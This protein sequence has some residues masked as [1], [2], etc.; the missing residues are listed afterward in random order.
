[1]QQRNLKCF[2]LYCRLHTTVRSQWTTLSLSKGCFTD[3]YNNYDR[4]W[5]PFRNKVQVSI[6][7]TFNCLKF[8]PVL[9]CSDS[10][11]SFNAMLFAFIVLSVSMRSSSRPENWRIISS[12]LSTRVAVRWK[13]DWAWFV[14]MIFHME[15]LLLTNLFRY[16]A[17]H[18]W[19]YLWPQIWC[20]LFG[21]RCH[22]LLLV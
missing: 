6:S 18:K 16:N 13:D 1:M 17:F 4:N 11:C 10:R 8:D 15:R 19:F 7:T 14:A 9:L 3:R 20:L 12:I 22:Y 5:M 21:R 2:H